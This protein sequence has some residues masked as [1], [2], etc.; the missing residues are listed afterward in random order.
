MMRERRG[1]P[2]GSGWD[3]GVGPGLDAASGKEF[4]PKLYRAERKVFNPSPSIRPV[5]PA[6]QSRPVTPGT[7]RS[8]L[9]VAIPANSIQQLFFLTF[10]LNSSS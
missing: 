5:N 2:C 8:F 1:F 3:G 6:R 4:R 7:S 10:L 9:N